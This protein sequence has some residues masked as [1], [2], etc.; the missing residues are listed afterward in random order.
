MG[1]KTPNPSPRRVRRGPPCPLLVPS[2]WRS[3]KPS[4]RR[5]NGAEWFVRPLCASSSKRLHQRGASR[6][7]ARFAPLD[8]GLTSN[9]GTAPPSISGVPRKGC[10]DRQCACRWRP[11]AWDLALARNPVAAM[12]RRQRRHPHHT[13]T[14]RRARDPPGDTR[15][16]RV[17]PPQDPGGNRSGAGF[18]R[19]RRM[20]SHGHDRGILRPPPPGRLP[21]AWGN[22]SLIGGC[23]GCHRDARVRGCSAVGAQPCCRPIAISGGAITLR[24]NFQD[25]GP[26]I[27][28]WTW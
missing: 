21:I 22:R 13:S 2:H 16:D 25:A 9:F 24:S 12:S 11:G 6:Y 8:P 27:R 3:L 1:G 10:R 15:G 23:A 7:V 18:S 26:G 4:S 19:H 17:E 28:A 14:A 20:H 5:L